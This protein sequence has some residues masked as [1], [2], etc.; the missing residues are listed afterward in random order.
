MTALQL[1]LKRP[2]QRPKRLLERPKPVRPV[3]IASLR[4]LLQ[5]RRR[6]QPTLSGLALPKLRRSLT[7]AGCGVAPNALVKAGQSNHLHEM[8][9]INGLQSAQRCP[10]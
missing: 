3:L 1:R 6:R 9:D 5:D 7:S 10:G 4:R 2:R 8:V